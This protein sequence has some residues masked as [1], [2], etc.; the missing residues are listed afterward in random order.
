MTPL[1]ILAMSMAYVVN[2]DDEATVEENAKMTVVLHRHVARGEMGEGEVRDFSRTA[3][4]MARK[5]DID[6]F[7]DL[8][9]QALTPG[10][11]T[12]VLI[13]LHDVMTADGDMAEAERSVVRK[14]EKAFGTDAKTVEALEKVFSVKNDPSLFSEGD[15]A[16][17]GSNRP[18]ILRRIR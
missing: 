1:Q 2:A 5:T 15:D 4:E 14:F 17:K 11:K 12:A 10:Q 3:Y 8:A 13:N 16:Q 9:E 18:L 7:L 6:R